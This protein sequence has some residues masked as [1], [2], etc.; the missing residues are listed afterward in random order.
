MFFPYSIVPDHAGVRPEASS[1]Y[2]IKVG[3]TAKVEA[4]GTAVSP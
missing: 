1:S 2:I 3:L 4:V